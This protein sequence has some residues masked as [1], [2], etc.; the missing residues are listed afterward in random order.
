MQLIMKLRFST[1]NVLG[2]LR[3]LVWSNNFY[4]EICLPGSRNEQHVHAYSCG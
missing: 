3:V 2:K 1:A 4:G